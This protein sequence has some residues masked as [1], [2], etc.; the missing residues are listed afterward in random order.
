MSIMEETEARHERNEKRLGDLETTHHNL[1]S[2]ALEQNKDIGA[3]AAKAASRVGQLWQKQTVEMK[4]EAH[5]AQLEERLEKLEST[6]RN[7]I[8][9]CGP[10]WTEYERPLGTEYVVGTVQ[11][12]GGLPT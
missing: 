3:T 9:P 2:A 12:T 4:L 5:K 1:I 7:T 8:L 11:R 6:P 10:Q